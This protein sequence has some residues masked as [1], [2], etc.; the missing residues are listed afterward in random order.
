MAGHDGDAASPGSCSGT[1]TDFD[2]VLRKRKD[3]LDGL[4]SKFEFDGET[5]EV[6]LTAEEKLL[7][8]EARKK[9]KLE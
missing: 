5:K 2:E 1:D 8:R 7:L 6:K 3:T 4:L 9:T